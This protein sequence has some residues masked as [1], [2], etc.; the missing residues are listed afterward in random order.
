MF[1][2]HQGVSV[3]DK[4]L[5][6]FKV[7]IYPNQ[8]QI[9]NIETNFN[10]ARFVYNHMLGRNIKAY[11]RRGEHLSAFDMNYLL[12]GM[13]QYLPWLKE[14]DSTSLT[15]ACADLSDAYQNFF[16]KQSSFPKFK[17]G[18][19]P[20]RSYRSTS[21]ALK[22]DETYIYLPK[23]GAVRYRD[24]RK[25]PS[26][27]KISQITVSKNAS[28]QYF[29]SALMKLDA[30]PG[31]AATNSSVGIDLGIK[32]FLVTSDGDK[33][34]N[35]KWFSAAEKRLAKAQRALSRKQKGSNNFKKQKN[36]VARIHQRIY[37]QRH[38][39][40]HKLANDMIHENQ[41]ICIESLR[42]KNM[43]KNH[44]LAKQIA[45]AAWS[46][47]V[48]KLQYKA[49]WH[50]RQIIQIDTFFASSQVCHCCGAKNP[51]A[52]DLSVRNWVC[53]HCGY[54][55]DRDTNAARNIQKEGLRML[56]AS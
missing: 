5:Y 7:R 44:K 54:S 33:I 37:N 6:A 46:D 52:K 25:I 31:T 30:I 23:V 55:H 18:K 41:V 4:R 24:S 51:A 42:V 3:L 2:Y 35:P 1:L 36:R 39:F 38:D 50:G 15:S 26:D 13:K 22:L 10:C 40:Q 45:D 34:S 48:R 28:G 16:K 53:P 9:R 27:I 47:F 49:E 43:T 19:N 8:E 14:A 21:P 17:S 29:A 11:K 56:H 12:K 20:K 32:D